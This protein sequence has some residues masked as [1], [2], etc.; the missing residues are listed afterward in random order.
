MLSEIKIEPRAKA[1]YHIKGRMSKFDM[2]R[3]YGPGICA[4]P[5][6]KSRPCGKCNWDKF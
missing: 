1:R 5:F 3:Y 4:R 2:C 6:K